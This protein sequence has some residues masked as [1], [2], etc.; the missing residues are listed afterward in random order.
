MENRE[1]DMELQE[2]KLRIEALFNK[3]ALDQWDSSNKAV[4][5]NYFNAFEAN[6]L[7]AVKSIQPKAKIVSLNNWKR[8]A[9]AASFL[10]ITTS[11]YWWL[12]LNA[13][14]NNNDSTTALSIQQIP[15]EE[16]D[17]YI[18][19]ND[20]LADVDWQTELNNEEINISSLNTAI[21]NDSN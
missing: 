8:I 12:E 11:T 18:N 14:N 10:A 13:S 5:H 1:N 2:D 19:A 15:T 4:P 7:D 9:V 17:A 20:W 6:T 16:I 21:K 3:A